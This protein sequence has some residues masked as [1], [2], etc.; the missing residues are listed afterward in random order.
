MP[1]FKQTRRRPSLILE[2]HVAA[3]L[4]RV[5]KAFSALNA[6]PL[7][8][9]VPQEYKMQMFCSVARELYS[10]VIHFTYALQCSVEEPNQP[11]STTIKE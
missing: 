11:P 5:R 8:E 10:Q 1:R 9:D 3:A 6:I 2:P 7:L 4:Q